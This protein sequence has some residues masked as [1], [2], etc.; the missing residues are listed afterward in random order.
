[1][2]PVGLLAARSARSRSAISASLPASTLRET[3]SCC[4]PWPGPAPPNRLDW[5]VSA[6]PSSSTLNNEPGAAAV[7]ASRAASRASSRSV[8]AL[9]AS[10]AS[11]A[12]CTATRSASR[13]AAA[14]VASVALMASKV[15]PLS[16]SRARSA[17]P[18]SDPLTSPPNQAV[19]PPRS[20]PPRRTVCCF[21]PLGTS[22]AFTSDGGGAP[23]YRS[24]FPASR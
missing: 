10:R 3:S 17:E 18:R 7:G 21:A 2:D 15:S 16:M 14:A 5:P 8:A 24:G 23:P 22:L 6:K 9:W 1:M 4:V 20:R 11:A 19:S 12:R 13:W